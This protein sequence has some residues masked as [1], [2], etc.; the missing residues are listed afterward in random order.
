MKYLNYVKA[1]IAIAS[2]A[3]ELA[4]RVVLPAVAGI[5]PSVQATWE[6]MKAIWKQAGE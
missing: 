6:R 1:A 3:Y 4:V 2:L 5:M